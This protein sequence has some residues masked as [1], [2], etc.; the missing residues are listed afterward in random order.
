M[1][2]LGGW[3]SRAAR[4]RGQVR[5]VD[6]CTAAG[7]NGA[8]APQEKMSHDTVDALF[9]AARIFQEV[10]GRAP[11]LWT[12]DIDAAFRRVPVRAERKAVR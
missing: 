11:A 12:A 6:E 2:G 7:I 9:E 10:A 4:K 8:T 5:T 3:K 1:P